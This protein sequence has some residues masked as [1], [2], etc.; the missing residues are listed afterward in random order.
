MGYLGRVLRRLKVRFVNWLLADVPLERLRVL[1]LHVG[2]TSM[3][4]TSKSIIFHENMMD[5]SS[6]VA[7][8]M[9]YRSDSHR[10]KINTGAGVMYLAFITSG[11]GAPS[12]SA[13]KHTLYIDTDNQIMYYYDGSS[14]IPF[15]AVFK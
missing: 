9:W 5:P 11:S 6:T 4:V 12:G 7:G 14:W 3:K 13:P 15:G 1:D 8:E 10:I 2:Q